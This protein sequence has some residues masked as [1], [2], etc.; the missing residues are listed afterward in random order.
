MPIYEY[1]CSTCGRSFEELIIRK[2]DEREVRCTACPDSAGTRLMS[3]PAA[4]T[5]VAGA[6]PPRGRA[7]GPVG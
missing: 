2:A 1:V 4:R 3:A 5:G 6:A 7:C